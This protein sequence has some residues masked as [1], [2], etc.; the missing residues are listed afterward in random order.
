MK[1]SALSEYLKNG[2]N[3]VEGWCYPEVA[4]MVDVLDD[5]QSKR[6]CKG[7]VAEVGVHHGKLFLLL[8]STSHA[9]EQSYAIDVFDRQDLN[10][11]HSGQV[12]KQAFERIL[13]NLDTHKEANVAIVSAESTDMATHSH[14]RQGV[15]FFSVDGGHTVEHTIN[16]LKLAQQSII[17]EGIVILDDILNAHW[18][19]VIEGAVRFLLT[20]P[21]LV[22]FAVGYNKMLLANFSHA[23][24]YYD[25]MAASSLCKK[26]GVEICGNKV[27]AM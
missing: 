17:A 13:A 7:G 10:I 8:N 23:S 22:L 24:R 11:D 1:N 16:D 26:V 6:D 3:Q 27:I 25:L 15:R 5:A 9:N 20:K 4:D 2:F 18:L 21:T 12:N 19:G 14:I